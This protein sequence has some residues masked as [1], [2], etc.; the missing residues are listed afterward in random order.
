MLTIFAETHAKKM[1]PNIDDVLER[2]EV[3]RQILDVFEDIKDREYMI[4]EDY[5]KLIYLNIPFLD[6]LCCY[7]NIEP[8]VARELIIQE[9]VI[10]DNFVSIIR[11]SMK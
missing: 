8:I 1:C 7:K 6:M 2:F 10:Y 11:N 5:Q 4:F 9:Y 3:E